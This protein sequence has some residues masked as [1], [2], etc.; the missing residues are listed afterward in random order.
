MEFENEDLLPD[1]FCAYE[2][3][4]CNENNLNIDDYILMK[5]LL[6]RKSL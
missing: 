6:I 1:E 3:K 2:L 5:E 4:L